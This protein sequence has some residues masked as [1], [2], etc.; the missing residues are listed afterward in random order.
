[1][2]FQHEKINPQKDF[3]VSE[4]VWRCLCSASYFMALIIK[5][6]FSALLIQE[7]YMVFVQFKAL[8]LSLPQKQ[9]MVV[10]QQTFLSCHPVK[11]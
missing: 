1:M 4:C 6:E 9:N 5:N 3:S 10:H 11:L 7:V 8:I 2:S